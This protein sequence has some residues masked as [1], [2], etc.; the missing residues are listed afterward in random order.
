MS[1]PD[2]TRRWALESWFNL[3]QVYRGKLGSNT[4]YINSGGLPK[5]NDGSVKLE[6][7]RYY[8]LLLRPNE[9]SMKVLKK[10]EYVPIWKA[11]YGDEIIAIVELE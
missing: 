11:L 8:L 3:K 1:L 4:L 5:V 2:G 7:G 6:V 10:G 9:E